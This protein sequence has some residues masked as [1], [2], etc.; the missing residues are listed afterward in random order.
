MISAPSG[1]GKTTLVNRLLAET[2]HLLRSVSVTTRKR[3]RGEQ[4]GRDY[5]FITRKKFGELKR[6]G[7]LLE[8][9]QVFGNF[10]GTPR[11]GVYENIKDGRDVLLE[12]DVQGAMQIKKKMKNAKFIFIMPPSKEVLERRLKGRS[13]ENGAQI[14]ERLR[15][16][17]HELAFADRYNYNVVNDDIENALKELKKIITTERNKR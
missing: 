4:D 6:N 1:T 14:E 16:A 2:P 17:E 3:R 15:V 5:N 8:W 7:E 13:T 12:I 10:Y 9:A 11:A